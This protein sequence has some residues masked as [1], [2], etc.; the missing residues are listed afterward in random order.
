MNLSSAPIKDI[1]LNSTGLLNQVWIQFFSSL[2][3]GLKGEWESSEY[4]LDIISVPN[5]PNPPSGK[6]VPPNG[7]KPDAEKASPC[8]VE[9]KKSRTEFV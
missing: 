8:P 5:P 6:G 4:K 9:F 3:T 1:M 7:V 2:G